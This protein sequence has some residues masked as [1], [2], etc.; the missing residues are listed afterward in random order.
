MR[1]TNG[2]NRLLLKDVDTCSYYDKIMVL[3]GVVKLIVL[4]RGVLGNDR[5]SQGYSKLVYY[6]RRS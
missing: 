4:F 2:A 6:A 3:S 5:A 1:Y